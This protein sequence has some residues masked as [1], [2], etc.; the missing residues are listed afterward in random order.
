N[1][2]IRE[3][4]QIASSRPEVYENID[5]ESPSR[6]IEFMLKWYRRLSGRHILHIAN[7]TYWLDLDNILRNDQLQVGGARS[8]RG[9]NENQFFTD[10]FSFF[11]L[12]YRLQLERNSYVFLFGDYAYLENNEGNTIIRP[13]S[14]GIGMNY[15]TKAGIISISYAIGTAENIP[16]QPSRGRIHV[17]LI[18]QF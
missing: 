8:I 5:R 17:G 4:V 7:H 11:S 6:E 10:F 18:N 13:R 9:F 1:R 3:N 2:T 12:E 15:G 14:T 16:F